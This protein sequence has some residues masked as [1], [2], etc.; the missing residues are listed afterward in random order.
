[1][2]IIQYNKSSDTIQFM[3][4]S[5]YCDVILVKAC[6]TMFYIRQV[7]YFIH[8]SSILIA[9]HSVVHYK[10]LMSVIIIVSLFNWYKIDFTTWRKKNLLI[11]L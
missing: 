7:Y 1:M 9:W 5:S 10:V 3:T 6:P 4:Y 2:L 11:K 8:S